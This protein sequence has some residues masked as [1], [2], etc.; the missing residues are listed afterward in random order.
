M[1]N[2]I[3]ATVKNGQIILSHPLRWP[4]GTELIIKP[5]ESGS[6]GGTMVGMTEEAQGD[7]PESIARWLAA[8]DAIPPLVMTPAEEAEWQAARQAQREF[9]KA[10]FHDRAEKL[11]SLWES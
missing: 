6:R 3:T 1:M 8:F 10:T 9:E 11:R 2:S 7:D 4:D 5:A